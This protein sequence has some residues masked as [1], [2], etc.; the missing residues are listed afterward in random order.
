MLVFPAWRQVP[1]WWSGGRGSECALVWQQI[2]KILRLVGPL[3]P[4][5]CFVHCLQ[6]EE[7]GGKA[8]TVRLGRTAAAGAG[9]VFSF[10]RSCF[11]LAPFLVLLPVCS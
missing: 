6:F 4:G 2:Q 5:A 1:R 11:F 10:A 9:E 7:Q 8:Y 3:G